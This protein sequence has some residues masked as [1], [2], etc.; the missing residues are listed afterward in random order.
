MKHVTLHEEIAVVLTAHD[1]R[2]MT[3][4][5]IAHAVNDRG[6]FRTIYGGPAAAKHVR[7]RVADR[8]YRHLFERDGNGIRLAR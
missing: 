6:R 7:A 4:E 1:N 8:F 2:W 5:E 3:A